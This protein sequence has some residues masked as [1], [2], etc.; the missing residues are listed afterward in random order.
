[1]DTR[2]WNFDKHIDMPQNYNSLSLESLQKSCW[3]KKVYST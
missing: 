3:T 2:A 1:M